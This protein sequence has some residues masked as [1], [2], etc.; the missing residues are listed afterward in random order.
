MKKYGR[1]N[2]DNL[3]TEEDYLT[4]LKIEETTF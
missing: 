2:L 3:P 4:A 1:D